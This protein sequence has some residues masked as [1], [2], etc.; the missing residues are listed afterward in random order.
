MIDEM[1]PGR[2]NAAMLR[3]CDAERAWEMDYNGELGAG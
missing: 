2:R 1:F 3:L